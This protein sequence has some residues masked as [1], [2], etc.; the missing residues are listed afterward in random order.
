MNVPMLSEKIISEKKSSEKSPKFCR[1][2]CYRWASSVLWDKNAPNL[3]LAENRCWTLLGALVAYKAFPNTQVAVERKSAP[4][5][6]QPCATQPLGSQY[7]RHI[8]TTIWLLEFL[9]NMYFTLL[10]N[11]GKKCIDFVEMSRKYMQQTN[12]HYTFSHSKN[13]EHNVKLTQR[14]KGCIKK[15]KIIKNCDCLCLRCD[16]DIWRYKKCVLME[17][18]L[19]WATLHNSAYQVWKHHYCMHCR[20]MIKNKIKWDNIL[21]IYNLSHMHSYKMMRQ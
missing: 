7:W 5:S 15:Y 10:W 11:V 21:Y 19:R 12:A 2:L 13:R 20:D 9:I 17:N 3:F 18:L 8:N 16:H 1:S 14:F 4:H 6:L